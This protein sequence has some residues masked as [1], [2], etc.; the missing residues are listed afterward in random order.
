MNPVRARVPESPTVTVA[1]GPVDQT[2]VGVMIEIPQPHASVLSWW[3]RQVGDPQADL[4]WPHVTL[5]PPTPLPAERVTAVCTH[6]RKAAREAQPFVMH[7]SGT[8]TFRPISPVVFVQVAAGLAG[9]ELLER[10]IRSGPLRRELEFPY[11]PHVTVAQ[12][13]ADGALE[14]AYEGLA[15]FAARFPVASFQLFERAADG[16]WSRLQEFPLGTPLDRQSHPATATAAR[17][18]R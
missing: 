6:L 17:A 15:R 7:L 12:S 13:V 3:R 18:V 14:S 10:A 5:L 2:V 1:P 11:H 4:V 9:C 8:G 16:A